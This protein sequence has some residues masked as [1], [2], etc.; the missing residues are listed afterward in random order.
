MSKPFN[1]K[2]PKASAR[3]IAVLAFAGSTIAVPAPAVAQVA[4][5]APPTREEVQRG[6]PQVRPEQA[7]PRLDVEGGIERTPCALD[8]PEFAAIRFTLR[9]V[10]F[11]NLR[12]LDAA[13]LRSSWAGLEGTEQPVSAL[14]GIR[15]RA[16]SI[17]RDA[18]YIAA[19]EVPEQRIADGNVHF[20]VLM[21]KLVQVRVRG[22]AGRSERIIAGYL[23]HLTKRA[24][25]NRSEA[26]RYLLLASDV[27]G[28]N[29]RLTLRPAGTAPGDVIG[30]VT[31]LRTAVRL[32]AN[33]QNFGSQELGRWGGLLRAQL[34][35]LT[36]LGDRTTATFFTTSDFDEQ[37]TIQLGHDFRVGPEGLTV[38]GSFTYAWA[39]P[40]L[41]DGSNV[42]AHT[43]FATGEV[44]YPLVRRQSHSAH[45]A[46]GLD[47]ANQDVSFDGDDISEDRLRVGFLRLN[48]E[49]VSLNFSRKGTS[50]AEPLWRTTAAIEFRQGLDI[51]GAS[52]RCR[53]GG[54]GCFGPG[55]VPLSRADAD[56]SATLVRGSIYGE[57]RPADKLTFSL[58]LR[59]QY[60][61]DPLLSFEQFSGGN[62]TVGRGYDPGSLLG[63]RG[64]GVQAEVRL[65]S[66][67]PQSPRGLAAEPYAFFDYARISNESALAIT[68][69]SH[70]LSSVG[71]GV[72]ALWDRFRLDAVVAVPLQKAGFF[73][74]KPDPR[75]LVSLSTRLWPGS[76][77]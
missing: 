70:E 74:T 36:G 18:G 3:G 33:V 56:S 71:G 51:F 25:F 37:K 35:G 38:S 72:R 27:P 7:P 16:A 57:Y 53:G 32:D 12:G 4:P 68:G 44:G 17:L 21:A 5:P 23:E 76:L 13:R 11:D 41:N 61:E 60:T 26:E 54:T 14:C 52:H 46:I 64:V 22:D 47:V 59:G 34:F 6:E 43:L 29:V 67:V 20:N 48:A 24:V 39:H 28:Y 73:D 65:G 19:I 31:V 50:L 55:E 42:R 77:Q 66:L 75:F 62:Y 49:A 63:D 10:R 8:N 45:G 30:D 58:G 1:G 15:D 9:D 69:R 40:D 2:F